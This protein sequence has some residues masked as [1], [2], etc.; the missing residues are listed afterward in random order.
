MQNEI[1]ELKD[2]IAMNQVVNGEMKAIKDTLEYELNNKN[3]KIKA[4]EEER[5]SLNQIIKK[6]G[7]LENEANKEHHEIV[8]ELEKKLK[9]ATISNLFLEDKIREDKENLA[10]AEAHT[11]SQK[12]E[13]FNVLSEISL[14]KNRFDEESRD[15]E[16]D[17]KEIEILKKKIEY[18]V[19]H[20]RALKK[21]MDLKDR[22]IRS[23]QSQLRASNILPNSSSAGSVSQMNAAKNSPQFLIEKLRSELQDSKEACQAHQAHSSFLSSEVLFFNINLLLQL[24]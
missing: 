7:E 14:L 9:E 20:N 6:R 5:D 11:I 19:E 16:N 15:H 3:T 4:L 22:N 17:L 2:V 21:E 24:Y 1:E 12:E 18:Y 8:L 13:L 10:S 23:F